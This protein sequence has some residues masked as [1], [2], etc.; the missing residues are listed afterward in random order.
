M[1]GVS[2]I[3]RAG[4][5]KPL[6]RYIIVYTHIIPYFT[7]NSSDLYWISH[8]GAVEKKKEKEEKKRN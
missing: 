7:P 3:T 5:F 6:N 1:H 8:V 2:T 4:E